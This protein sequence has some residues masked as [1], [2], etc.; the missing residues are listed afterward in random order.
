MDHSFR[1]SVFLCFDT[2]FAPIVFDGVLGPPYLARPTVLC[3]F[4]L[5]VTEATHAARL[6][7][8]EGRHGSSKKPF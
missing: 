6:R 8:L 5:V 1:K 4:I 2:G 3:H 7:A